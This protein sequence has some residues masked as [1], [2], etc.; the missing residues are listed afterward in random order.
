MRYIVFLTVLGLLLGFAIGQA[1][2]AGYF[3]RWQKV[4]AP[5][6]E[7]SELVVSGRGDVYARTSTSETYRCTS[8]LEE[9]WVPGQV[10]PDT[11]WSEYP[12]VAVT[13]PC[14]LSAPE[15]FL[16]AGPPKDIIDCIQDQTTYLD[17]EI[18][19]YDWHHQAS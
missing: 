12:E 13:E 1:N 6:T 3:E 19:V 8:W 4:V 16:L 9:C 5:P 17:F 14:D 18:T 15:F 7:L 11:S 2:N 10:P